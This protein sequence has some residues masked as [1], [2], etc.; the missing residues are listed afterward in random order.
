MSPGS[1]G[2]CAAGI[3]V[4]LALVVCATAPAPAQTHAVTWKAATG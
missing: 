2:R 1:I 4:T 3:A